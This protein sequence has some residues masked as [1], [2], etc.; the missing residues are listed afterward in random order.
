MLCGLKA[1]IDDGGERGEV[2]AEGDAVS[3]DDSYRNHSGEHE[4]QDELG[5]FEEEEGEQPYSGCGRRLCQR[6]DPGHYLCR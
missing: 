5:E 4:E 2:D 1:A 6:K 3:L